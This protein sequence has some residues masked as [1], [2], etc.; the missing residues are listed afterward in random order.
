MWNTNNSKRIYDHMYTK[1]VGI[2]SYDEKQKLNKNHN[3]MNFA[4]I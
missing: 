1:R 3:R 4:H 2:V